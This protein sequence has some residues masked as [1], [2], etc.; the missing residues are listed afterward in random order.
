MKK[1]AL[2]LLGEN[3]LRLFGSVEKTRKFNQPKI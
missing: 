2:S 3:G 1:I